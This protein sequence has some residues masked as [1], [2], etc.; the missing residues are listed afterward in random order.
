[1]QK[2]VD[3][4]LTQAIRKN[5]NLSTKLSK[6]R[7]ISTP[8]ILIYDRSSTIL[9]EY[10]NKHVAIHNGHEFKSCGKIHLSLVGHK[11][12]EFSHTKI[13]AV[14]KKKKSKK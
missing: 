6:Y 4:L 3:P 7:T 13:P 14:Y 8:H 10:L 11:F 12:G 2:F 1:M 5:D 9:P